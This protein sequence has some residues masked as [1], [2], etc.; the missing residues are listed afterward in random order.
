MKSHFKIL[1]SGKYRIF[2]YVFTGF[3]VITI[4]LSFIVGIEDNPAGIAILSIGIISL[5]IS[6]THI[7]RSKKSFLILAI[8]SA[9]GFPFFIVLHNI[10]NAISE[11]TTQMKII[12]ELTSFLDAVSFLIA[13]LICPPGILV[14][15]GGLIILFIR[16]RSRE[17]DMS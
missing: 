7:W 15:L 4:L 10:F 13:M 1:F 12:P 3:A 9:V 8:I 14:G 16:G 17:I 5:F 11:L 6:L 2:T